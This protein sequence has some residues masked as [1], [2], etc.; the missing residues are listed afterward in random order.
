MNWL[1]FVL[2]FILVVSVA[3]S[4]RKG[5]SREVIG[6][7]SVVLALLLG[8]WFYGT[9]G[10][11]L[12][13]YVSSPTVANFAGF[14]M[15][16]TGVMLLGS[17]VSFGAGKFLKMTGLSIADHALGAGFGVLRA[18]VVSIALIM[19]IMAFSQGDKAPVAVVDSRLA[20]Y[21]VDAARLF[22]AMAPHDLKQGFWKSYEQVKEAWGNTLEKG[23]RSVP[24][25]EK[26]K[27][28]R[29]I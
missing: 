11:F 26:K 13:P 24:N 7:V 20:P 25:G 28:E 29:A 19:G 12:L 18:T 1:D 23:L 5:L 22:A 14:F 16:F 10:S 3:T 6:L 27:H 21:V 4:F 2:G 9:A 17:L 8:T 15:V